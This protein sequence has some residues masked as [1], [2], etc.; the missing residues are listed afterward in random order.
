MLHQTASNRS[1]WS[2]AYWVGKVCLLIGLNM[3]ALNMYYI[4]TARFVENEQFTKHIYCR[5]SC[6]LCCVLRR[7]W[8]PI[9]IIHHNVAHVLLQLERETHQ[10]HHHLPCLN[11]L[12]LNWSLHCCPQTWIVSNE[13]R[14]FD[15]DKKPPWAEEKNEFPRQ[16]N[17]KVH[18]CQ[19]HVLL[20]DEVMD[21]TILQSITVWLIYTRAWNKPAA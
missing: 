9:G 18:L 21:C 8:R 15:G 12:E 3:N 14:S 1:A 13:G 4:S 20:D 11:L 2:V 19:W 16:R 10:F 17:S 6:K 5:L 7:G